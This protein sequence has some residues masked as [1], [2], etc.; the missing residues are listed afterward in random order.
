MQALP[1]S[2]DTAREI[3]QLCVSGDRAAAHGDFATLRYVS[4]QLASWL[5]D[6]LH[7]YLIELSAACSDD[8]ERASSLWETLKRRILLVEE[9]WRP[10]DL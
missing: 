1:Y 4:E 5:P 3:G 2:H 9:A 7:V 8:R 10:S 6:E